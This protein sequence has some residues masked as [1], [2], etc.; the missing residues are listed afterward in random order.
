MK[1]VLPLFFLFIV[2]CS[3]ESDQRI[4]SNKE[5]IALG[6]G[7]N[8]FIGF[9]GTEAPNSIQSIKSAISHEDTKG[10]E[11]DCQLL[12]DGTLLLYHD[13]FLE[14]Q[15]HCEGE[16]AY[17]Y[18]EEIKNCKYDLIIESE[19]NVLFNLDGLLR[20][21]QNRG[22]TISLD[23]KIFPDGRNRD[24]LF[25]E[26]DRAIR[27]SL[28][29]NDFDGTLF[30]ESNSHKLLTYL[31]GTRLPARLYFYANEFENGHKIALE[32]GFDG[33]SISNKNI[34]SSQ[35][36]SAQKNGL[37]VMIF[38]AKNERSNLEVLAKGPDYLQTD[39]L[40]HIQTLIYSNDVE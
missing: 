38:G 19:E 26:F 11:V 17:A 36:S 37:L 6:H 4:P 23:I 27:K 25:V 9:F 40:K 18:W 8:G 39:D 21:V 29:E 35:V 7:G 20:L 31:K 1:C 24:S 14:S 16:V 10:I 13:Q 28:K 30:I 22:L 3:C 34:T 33:L 5:T 2:F 15:T 12:A 32:K